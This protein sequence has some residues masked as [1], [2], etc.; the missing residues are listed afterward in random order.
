MSGKFLNFIEWY[1]V[2]SF[3]A[4]MRILLILAKNSWKN[5][6]LTFPVV[7]YSTWKL[8]LVSANFFIREETFDVLVA[9]SIFGNLFAWQKMLVVKT[10][11]SNDWKQWSSKKRLILS[12]GLKISPK[13]QIARKSI[14]KVGH[15]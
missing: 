9:K 11:I 10:N 1:L 2:P 13:F 5:R 8:E 12:T 15:I 6:K 3:P 4:E 7:R 14:S